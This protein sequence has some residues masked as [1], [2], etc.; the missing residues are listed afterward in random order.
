MRGS[1]KAWIDGGAEIERMAVTEIFRRS[2]SLRANSIRPP[3]FFHGVP[4]RTARVTGF[5]PPWMA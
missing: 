3:T 4:G 1:S 5:R 2:V